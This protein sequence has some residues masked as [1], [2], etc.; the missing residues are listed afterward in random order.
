MHVSSESPFLSSNSPVLPTPAGLYAYLLGDHSRASDAD[1]QAAELLLAAEPYATAGARDNR[2]FVTRSSAYAADLGIGQFIDMGAGYPLAEYPAIHEIAPA[3]QVTYADIDPAVVAAWTG[4][5]AS[6]DRA[7]VV[8]A[9][10]RDPAW[11]LAAA[12][13]AGG[14][15]PAAPVCLIF[16]A[17]LN[18]LAPDQ[19]RPVVGRWT[20]LIA[21]G[22]CVI[23]SVGRACSLQHGQDLMRTYRAAPT[24]H[25]SREEIRTWFG[26]L[27]LVDPG[28]CAA[29]DWRAGVMREEPA[30]RKAEVWCGVGL[31]PAAAPY[32]GRGG[33]VITVPAQDTARKPALA[34]WNDTDELLRQLRGEWAQIILRYLPNAGRGDR[35]SELLRK[36]NAGLLEGHRLHE[37]TFFAN[38]R[39][40]AAK[41]LAVRT[42]TGSGKDKMTFYRRTDSGRAAVDA[43][44]RVTVPPAGPLLPGLGT[45]TGDDSPVPHIARVYDCCLG[46]THFAADAETARELREAM[47]SVARLLEEGRAFTRRAVRAVIRDHG[48]TQFICIGDGLPSPGGPALHETAIEQNPRTRWV[49][50]DRDPVVASRLAGLLAAVPTSLA[51]VARADLREPVLALDSAAAAGPVDLTRPVAVMLPGV[52]QCITDDEDPAGIVRRLM[53][54]APPG[55]YLILSHPARDGSPDA[56]PG[57]AA[58]NRRLAGRITFRSREAMS[59]ILQGLQMLSPGLVRYQ[60]WRPGSSPAEEDVAG[61]C[62]VARRT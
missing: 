55:S 32:P 8:A 54:A 21:P 60:Q 31:K 14:L 26:D 25:P 15:D 20:E 38:L 19:V 43:L 51:A 56:G 17:V 34:D 37:T 3:A 1:R 52:L 28:M 24:F 12:A 2:E 22:S 35:P 18:F 39:R 9:D 11:S 7:I 33:T 48:I 27:S 44:R 59:R 13:R 46:G 30:S 6:S 40:L 29:P 41:G 10:L 53:Q 16:G 50:L 36:I 47:P 49:Y 4:E 61:W 58:L 23:I 62:A 57:A 45:G 42:E 5:L